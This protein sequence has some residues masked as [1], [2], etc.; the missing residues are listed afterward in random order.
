MLLDLDLGARWRKVDGGCFVRLVGK[1][2]T[3]IQCALHFLFCT[4]DGYRRQESTVLS[5]GIVV[6][7]GARS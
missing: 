4:Q 2:R 3:W 5:A 1:A 7:L 6:R